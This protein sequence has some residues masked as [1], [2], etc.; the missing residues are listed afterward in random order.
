MSGSGAAGFGLR[1]AKEYLVTDIIHL[2]LAVTLDRNIF[3][4][5]FREGLVSVL[6]VPL[7]RI[8]TPVFVTVFGIG[9]INSCVPISHDIAV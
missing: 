2:I 7:K 5:V 3:F 4:I 9:I 8:L 1:H 6:Q